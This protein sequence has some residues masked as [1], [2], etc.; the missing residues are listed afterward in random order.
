LPEAP[1]DCGDLAELSTSSVYLSEQFL[2]FGNNPPLF[3]KRRHREIEVKDLVYANTL[4]SRT[5][6]AIPIQDF[7][8]VCAKIEREPFI[9]LAIP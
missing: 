3:R 9:Q 6:F 1:E 4:D 8:L 7:A 2:D 5:I